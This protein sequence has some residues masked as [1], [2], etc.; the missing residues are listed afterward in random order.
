M[1]VKEEGQ[2]EKVVRLDE[3]G[4]EIPDPT[5]VEM[6]LNFKRPE[7]IQE[8]IRRLVNVQNSDELGA[9]TWEE[10][11][12][13][14]VDDDVDFNTEYEEE[15]DP[16]LGR[17]VTPREVLDHD[18]ELRAEMAKRNKIVADEPSAS[19]GEQEDGL[20]SPDGLK[21]PPADPQAPGDPAS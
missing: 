5:P 18:R 19:P 9:E 17:S 11:N 10:A 2:L 20:T 6:P 16:L 13:F 14:D 21:L 8:M 4:R 12:D 1:D 15:F 7:T 3:R